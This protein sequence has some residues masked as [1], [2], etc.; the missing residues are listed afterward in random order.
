MSAMLYWDQSK[1]VSFLFE[2]FYKLNNFTFTVIL[3]FHLA[4][5]LTIALMNFDHVC[6][7]I[8]GSI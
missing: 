2:T 5:V 3:L 1:L 4:R 7:T 6:Y 8:L